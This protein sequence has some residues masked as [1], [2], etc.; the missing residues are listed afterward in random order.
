MGNVA[1]LERA[2]RRFAV[3]AWIHVGIAVVGG[4]VTLASYNAASAGGSYVAFK[5][6]IVL[7][8]I[9]AIINAVRYFRTRSK[10]DAFK[11]AARSSS[12]AA[13]DVSTQATAR[14]AAAGSQQRLQVFNPPPGW[15]RPAEGWRPGPDWRP[16]PSWPARPQGW[17]LLV[18]PELIM[19]PVDLSGELHLGPPAGVSKKRLNEVCEGAAD[20]IAWHVCTIAAARNENPLTTLGHARE[21]VRTAVEKAKERIFA[22]LLAD[23]NSWVQESQGSLHQWEAALQHTRMIMEK[24]EVFDV[25]AHKRINAV[26]SAAVAPPL[27]PPAPSPTRQPTQPAT[28][29]NPPRKKEGYGGLIAVIAALVVIGVGIFAIGVSQPGSSTSASDAAATVAPGAD[30]AVVKELERQGDWAQNGSF[31][32]KWVA[33]DQYTCTTG[34]ACT[35]VWLWTPLYAGCKSAE[36]M[37]DLLQ[38]GKTIGTASG[39]VS[40]LTKDSPKRVHIEARSGLNPDQV[41]INHVSC[42]N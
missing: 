6:A 38:K 27:R 37:V 7:G 15:P 36:A 11:R 13:H 20:A 12:T 25:R 26:I 35:E 30:P 8:P 17:N 19:T 10:I 24:R 5:G 40:N 9:F 31:Y 18:D 28:A 32:L 41:Q 21:H 14:P 2:A 39:T 4:L 1:E 42:K 33:H 29:Y 16:D 34:A 23:A 22:K 3:W